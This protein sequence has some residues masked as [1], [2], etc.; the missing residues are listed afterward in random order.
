MTPTYDQTVREFRDYLQQIGYGKSSVSMLPD[1]VKAF[2][3]SQGHI[4]IDEMRSADIVRFYRW[5]RQRPHKRKEGALSEQYIN[6]HLYALRIFFGWLETTG[7]IGENPISTMKFKSPVPNRREPF[8]QGEIKALFQA[9]QAIE[10]TAL[11]HLFYSCGLRRAEAVKLNTRDIHFRQ[12]VLY[13]REGKGAKRRAVPMTARVSR[14]LE[15]YYLEARGAAKKAKDTE[16]FMLN[17]TG[18]RMSGD[19][20]NRRLKEIAARTEI[21]REISLHYLRHSIA[22]HLL[23]SG[24]PVE[25][26]RDFLGHSHLE[27]TQIYAKVHQN[28]IRKL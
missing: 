12:Q 10:E 8:T 18:T 6:H 2:L 7:R 13:V 19:S 25:Q 27:A 4:P 26:V 14:E 22:T 15:N 5:L 3:E 28:Q 11:L 9:C 23:E 21:K 16:A 1:C 17:G 24:L 20:Y